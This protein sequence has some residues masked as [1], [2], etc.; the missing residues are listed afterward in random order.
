LG[1]SDS[2]HCHGLGAVCA[3]RHHDA[4]TSLIPAL[5]CGSCRLNAPVQVKQGAVELLTPR[6]EHSA[7][8]A[9]AGADIG[10]MTTRSPPRRLAF[11]ISSMD[12]KRAMAIN[13]RRERRH[14]DGC[15]TPQR[16]PG[17]AGTGFGEE[18]NCCRTCQ[19]ATALGGGVN[20]PVLSHRGFN[21]NGL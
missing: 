19:I 20:S 6:M 13:V 14:F 4:L 7:A 12:L 3:V 21:R 18:R 2:R 10:R 15:S 16:R 11:A 17:E 9:L 8:E 5:S 1:P